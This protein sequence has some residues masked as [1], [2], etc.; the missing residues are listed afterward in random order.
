ML[1]IVAGAGHDFVTRWDTAGCGLKPGHFDLDAAVGAVTRWDTAGC[2]LKQP[3]CFFMFKMC[4][5]PVGHRRV[6]IETSAQPRCA[7]SRARHPVGHRRVWIETILRLSSFIRPG[8]HPAGHHRVWIET[9]V[10]KPQAFECRRHPVGHH[11]VW[12]ETST[13]P[14]AVIPI[15]L[16]PGGSPPGVD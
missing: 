11:R 5:H 10:R 1:G 2:G 13:S 14:S 3:P 15:M 9:T 7:A 12:I 8:S 16:S 4:G 6:W